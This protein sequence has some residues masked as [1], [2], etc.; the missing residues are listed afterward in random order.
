[1]KF[2][3]F[4]PGFTPHLNHFHDDIIQTQNKRFYFS[5]VLGG[6]RFWVPLQRAKTATGATLWMGPTKKLQT[7]RVYELIFLQVFQPSHWWHT[8]PSSLNLW[9]EPLT[10][11]NHQIITC[12]VN[13]IFYNF[14]VKIFVWQYLLHISYIL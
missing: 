2:K 7:W 4:L 1:M 3:Y 8:L 14:K 12:S 5:Y 6:W 13:F 9:T 10:N 11:N